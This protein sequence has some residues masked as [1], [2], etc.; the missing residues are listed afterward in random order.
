M[1]KT[2]TLSVA[3]IL[4]AGC[5]GNTIAVPNSG[6]SLRG[7]SIT[8]VKKSYPTHPSI[9]TDANIIGNVVGGLIGGAIIASTMSKKYGDE[10][11]QI[12][13][14]QIA[15]RL[16]GTISSRYSMNYIPSSKV[17]NSSMDNYK[18]IYSTDYLLDVET[19]SDGWVMNHSTMF[20]DSAS[21]YLGNNV[22]IIH[23]LSGKTVAQVG[24]EYSKKW[25]GDIPKYEDILANNQ[26]FIKNY[27]QKA[28][29][30]CVAKVQREMLK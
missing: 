11:Y 14:N 30:E 5:V 1:K 19:P 27:T 17:S 25:E 7:K 26:Q 2:V 10:S 28:I 24:C 13:S 21:F 12:P 16:I 9:D 23:R 22:K 8:V 15:D 29:D 20:T 4:L 18:N 6:A 3:A